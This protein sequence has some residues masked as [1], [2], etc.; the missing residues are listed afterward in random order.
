MHLTPLPTLPGT[1]LAHLS[2]AIA[3]IFTPV[4]ST[5]RLRSLWL[6]QMRAQPKTVKA[7]WMSARRSYGWRGGGSS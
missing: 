4:L 3:R 2:L 1:V 7:S 5:S 6:R